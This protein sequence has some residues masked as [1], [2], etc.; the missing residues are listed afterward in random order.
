MD[1]GRGSGRNSADRDRGFG[2]RR[3]APPSSTRKA[4]R[5]RA[6]GSQGAREAMNDCCTSSSSQAERRSSASATPPTFVVR[7]AVTFPDWSIV[8]SPAVRDALQ[9][10]AGSDHVLNRWSGYDPITDRVRVALLQL[11]AENGRAPSPG[12]LA[13]RTGL[14]ETAIWPQL[15]E[16]RRHDLVVL[17]RER[18]VGAYPFSDRETGHR[19]TL[20]GCVVNAMCAVDALGIGAMTDRDISIASR[21][22]HCGAP[23]RITT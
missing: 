9:A 23:I 11:Y 15:E 18:I 19:V 17:D 1:G 6:E 21:C 22:R 12:A 5:L 4:R 14:N 2:S 8:S 3:M 10:M 20:D 13:E 7:Q 16:L